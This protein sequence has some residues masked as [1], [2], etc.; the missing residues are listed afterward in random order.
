MPRKPKEGL[1][2][3]MQNPYYSAFVTLSLVALVEIIFSV[4]PLII[5]PI[6]FV[7]YL[8]LTTIIVSD[9]EPFLKKACEKFR[10]RAL[11]KRRKKS[12]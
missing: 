8:C 11:S 7:A 9:A 2:V 3:I 10:R 4:S 5:L 12:W 6:I 1:L